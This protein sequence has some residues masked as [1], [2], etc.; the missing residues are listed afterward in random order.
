MGTECGCKGTEVRVSALRDL[1]PERWWEEASAFY[2]CTFKPGR[3]YAHLLSLD[4]EKAGRELAAIRAQGF[5][6][7]EVFAPAEGRCGYAGLDMTDPYNVDRELGTMDDFRRFVRM[8]HTNG[9]AVVIFLNIG[10]FSLEAPAWLE[11]CADK[12]AGR[13]TEKVRWFS[14]ADSPDAPPPTVPENRA[15]SAGVLPPGTPD[16]PK[17]WGWQKS[18]EAGCYYWARWQA[19][20]EDGNW[21]GLP[22]TDWGSGTWPQ[23]AERIIRFWMDTGIDGIIVDAP[24][25]YSQL[26]WERNN[27]HITGPIASYGNV[28]IQAEGVGEPAWI[29]EGGYNCLQDYRLQERL[30]DAWKTGDPRPI[31]ECL[32]NYHDFVVG[33]GG[34]MYTKAYRLD[35]VEQRRLHAAIVVALGET[36][37]Y[38]TADK[39]G[40][41]EEERWLLRLRSGNRAFH[42]NA[43]RRKLPTNA[44][45]KHYAFLKTASDGSAR[46]VVVS[47]FSASAETVEVDLSTVAGAG[48]IDL[49]TARRIERE[50][51]LR[52]P[53]PAYGYAYFQV[54]P[55]QGC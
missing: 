39:P 2:I 54:I 31:E 17:T 43:A 36:L 38:G 53:L 7:V 55:P 3:P 9:L 52:V 16:A 48:L 12:K 27:R 46:V 28:Y 1:L 37:V 34:V 30:A 40:P 50:P 21:I 42:H 18:E 22:Q 11:A 49:K 45:E 24:C 33:A 25:C 35:S 19:K 20:D 13:D 44:D 14:W 5:D 15:F 10:Y 47:N 26:T 41:D 51:A 32:R 29:S 6:V 8:A 23:E 4:P